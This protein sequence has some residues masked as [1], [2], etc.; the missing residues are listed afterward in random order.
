MLDGAGDT[1]TF[2]GG[3]VTVLFAGFFV[4]GR[5]ATGP[6][7][8]VKHTQS[9][10]F[11]MIALKTICRGR[12]DTTVVFDV[13]SATTAFCA[14]C[15]FLA[16][17]VAILVFAGAYA[18]S[19]NTTTIFQQALSKIFAKFAFLTVFIREKSAVFLSENGGFRAIP[20]LAAGVI[21]SFARNGFTTLGCRVE[22]THIMCF[23]SFTFF[24]VGIV[25]SETKGD[26]WQCRYQ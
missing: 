21:G 8:F 1:T 2:T 22:R 15:C 10:S 25:G 3:T 13:K 7:V 20:I 23:A 11:A 18:T 19:S 17:A 12:G 6:F 9:Q 24:A 4:T 14:G 5:F 26:N 16:I